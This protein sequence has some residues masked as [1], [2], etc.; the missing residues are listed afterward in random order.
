MNVWVSYKICVVAVSFV[1]A[2]LVYAQL[3]EMT[4]QGVEEKI[5]EDTYHTS[6]SATLTVGVLNPVEEMGFCAMSNSA[7]CYNSGNGKPWSNPQVDVSSL[8]LDMGKAIR[9]FETAVTGIRRGVGGSSVPIQ[10]P[11][12]PKDRTDLDWHWVYSD[13]PDRPGALELLDNNGNGVP[14]GVRVTVDPSFARAEYPGNRPFFSL[15]LDLVRLGGTLDNGQPVAP[16]TQVSWSVDAEPG[17]QEFGFNIEQFPGNYRLEFQRFGAVID[18]VDLSA[19]PPPFAPPVFRPESEPVQVADGLDRSFKFEIERENGLP[20]VLRVSVDRKRNNSPQEETPGNFET[21]A[22]FGAG[23]K[24]KHD[25][26]VSRVGDITNLY[27]AE[28]F[29][30]FESM[31]ELEIDVRGFLPGRYAIAHIGT[32]APSKPGE[33][34]RYGDPILGLKYFDVPL[35]DASNQLE[36]IGVVKRDKD[37]YG[38]GYGRER[39]EYLTYDYVLRWREH[40]NI[41]YPES[42]IIDAISPAQRFINGPYVPERVLDSVQ[43]GPFAPEATIQAGNAPGTYLR[44]RSDHGLCRIG[45]DDDPCGHR[46]FGRIGL[47]EE[48]SLPI[49]E[50]LLEPIRADGAISETMQPWPSLVAGPLQLCNGAATSEMAEVRID[51]RPETP[52]KSVLNRAFGAKTTAIP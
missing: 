4:Y 2:P 23:A 24:A 28:Y 17:A 13:L 7:Q 42:V 40:E 50:H 30:D 47:P 48:N 16:T 19:P 33:P 8:T 18:H 22:I 26:C 32:G 9:V 31:S 14:D 10:G 38:E 36:I 49:P 3:P 1:C 12:E 52:E 51:P 21:F 15:R 29:L 44:I 20:S 45:Q 6:P 41:A 39:R 46:I 27:S 34:T 35:I 43:L 5:D 11:D 37:G 25:G